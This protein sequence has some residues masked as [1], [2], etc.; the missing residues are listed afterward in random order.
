MDVESVSGDNPARMLPEERASE[1]VV[2]LA[3]GV[4]RSLAA[5][6]SPLFADTRES[7]LD[8]SRPKSGRALRRVRHR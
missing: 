4:R 5:Q 7:S 1:I 6:S 2:I 3:S 8:F